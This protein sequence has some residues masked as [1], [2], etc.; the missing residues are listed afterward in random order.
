ME[1]QRQGQVSDAGQVGQE[2]GG[3]GVTTGGGG[4]HGSLAD[5]AAERLEEV[6]LREDVDGRHRGAERGRERVEE[7]RP[8]GRVGLGQGGGEGD[9]RRGRRRR[10]RRRGR[11]GLGFGLGT[12][13]EP[14]CVRVHGDGEEVD[15]F[16]GA[17][18]GG[19]DGFVVVVRGAVV[20]SV[21]PIGARGVVVGEHGVGEDLVA[22]F[23][24]E[25]AEERALGL[26]ID[27]GG[28][29]SIITNIGRGRF[30]CIR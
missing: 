14:E 9:G 8:G 19:G 2:E 21:R 20:E 1:A 10:R 17:E 24:G 26:G 23:G 3:V 15:T 29:C 5:R 18:E 6:L 25:E 22:E 27:H 30:V 16:A 11:L 28:G 4:G 13:E 7:G 12:A